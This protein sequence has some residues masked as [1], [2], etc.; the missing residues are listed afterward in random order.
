MAFETSAGA[1]QA[2]DDILCPPLPSR[3]ERFQRRGK[4]STLSNLF[5]G[6][7]GGEGGREGGREGRREGG[8][9][10][11]KGGRRGFLRDL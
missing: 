10:E 6:E 3:V 9:R 7:G 1:A 11:E 5:Q 2:L 4:F 8:R